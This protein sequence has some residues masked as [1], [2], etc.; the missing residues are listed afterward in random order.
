[1]DTNDNSGDLFQDE[2]SL[3]RKKINSI[4]KEN[5]VK[6]IIEDLIRLHLLR[7][8]SK[9]ENQLI[10]VEV[11]NL[12]GAEQFAELVE[13]INGRKIVFP[14]P[15]GF[16][17]TVEIALSYY[18]KYIQNRSWDEIKILLQNSEVSSIKY[19]INCNKLSQ[20]INELSSISAMEN[21]KE[22]A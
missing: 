21:Y 14:E 20:F 3:F 8:A 12:L 4:L 9:D 15:E 7:I 6:E 13:L 1:M 18:F 5:P 22:K 11:Y 10:L 2:K 19:G 17:E 16:K